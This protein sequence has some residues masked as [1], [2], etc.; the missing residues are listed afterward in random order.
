MNLVGKW[1]SSN[2][3]DIITL[4]EHQFSDDTYYFKKNNLESE[5][6]KVLFGVPNNVGVIRFTERSNYPI[7]QIIIHDHNFIEITE[8][9]FTTRLIKSTI[10]V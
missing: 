8:N 7:A 4:E 1:K 10:T 2:S 9:G 6:V 3:D 5:V